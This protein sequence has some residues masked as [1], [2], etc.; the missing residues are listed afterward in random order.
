MMNDQ[1]YLTKMKFEKIMK[2]ASNTEYIK[3]EKI[4]NANEITKSKNQKNKTSFARKSIF[5]INVFD[6]INLHILKN[7]EKN[8]TENAKNLLKN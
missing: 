7:T 8:N 4:E 6:L 2:L 5:E 1:T 3:N